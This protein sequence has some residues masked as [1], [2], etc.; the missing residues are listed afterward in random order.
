[1]TAPC[2]ECPASLCAAAVR[3]FDEDE[4]GMLGFDNGEFFFLVKNIL[5]RGARE[6][7]PGE[8]I[9]AWWLAESAAGISRAIAS[10]PG[11]GGQAGVTATSLRA[12]AL[13]GIFEHLTPA[14]R[15]LLGEIAEVEREAM[16]KEREIQGRRVVTAVRRGDRP[17]PAPLS[18]PPL[19]LPQTQATFVPTPPASAAGA[20]PAGRGLW[21]ECT[22]MVVP[23]EQLQ[24]QKYYQQ[25]QQEA[26]HR[27]MLHYQ[28]Q[29]HVLQQQMLQQQR[30]F[31][32]HQAQLSQH[33]QQQ[34]QQTHLSHGQPQNAYAMQ[35]YYRQMAPNFHSLVCS[36]LGPQ[37]A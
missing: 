17:R 24:Q 3:L 2:D 27:E 23:S 9:D 37:H 31:E 12:A 5:H 36:V 34:L 10:N 8:A 18:I 29:Q 21:W 19:E 4:D 15:A 22:A 20:V 26:Q 28:Q 6:A 30:G 1:M 25:L 11:F 32:A 35:N 33:S 14:F 13:S 16:E 7:R